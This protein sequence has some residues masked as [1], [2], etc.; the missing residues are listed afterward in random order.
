MKIFIILSQLSYGFWLRQDL[1]TC[2]PEYEAQYTV[3]STFQNWYEAK[4]RCEALDGTLAMPM[5]TEQNTKLTKYLEE[6]TETQLP[7]TSVNFYW[8]GLSRPTGDLYSD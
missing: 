6:Y 4:A 5:T 8:I 1:A 2:R 3:A 7:G